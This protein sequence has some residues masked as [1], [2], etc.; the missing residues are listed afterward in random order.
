[1]SVIMKKEDAEK[2]AQAIIKDGSYY[3]R[4][5]FYEQH[6][7]EIASIAKR[8]YNDEMFTFGVE[9]GILIAVAKIYGDLKDDYD[10]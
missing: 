8:F 10:N 1:M 2:W 5:A 6:E 9:Y 3:A 7:S 4:R